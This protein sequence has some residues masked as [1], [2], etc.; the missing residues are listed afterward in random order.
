MC[1]GGILKVK[2]IGRSS[3]EKIIGLAKIGS[4]DEKAQ[5]EIISRLIKVLG[6]VDK[7]NQ[8]N[9]DDI[10][11]MISPIWD[12]SVLKNENIFREDRV[13]EPLSVKNVLKNAPSQKEGQFKVVCF[14]E[15][16]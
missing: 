11:P 14:V 8:I 10:P 15:D 16:N 2:S 5:K 13:K 9:T 6:H 4:Q 1:L 12:E 3:I 7:L